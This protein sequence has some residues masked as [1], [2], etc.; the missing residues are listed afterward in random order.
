MIAAVSAFRLDH[1]NRPTFNLIAESTL[2][3]YFDLGTVAG[4]DELG[5]VDSQ[6]V[7]LE[8]TTIVSL[9]VHAGDDESCFNLYRARQP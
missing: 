5:L 9:R 1:E 7:P 3:I 8:K 4:R 2:P 6:Q